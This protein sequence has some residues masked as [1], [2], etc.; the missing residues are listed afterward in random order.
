MV[1]GG[2]QVRVSFWVR[3]R[4]IS[5]QNYPSDDL[6]VSGEPKAIL[7][8]AHVTRSSS[9]LTRSSSLVYALRTVWVSVFTCLM[10]FTSAVQRRRHPLWQLAGGAEGSKSALNHPA[11]ACFP[12][13]PEAALE[14]WSITL[15][16]RWT[17]L[18]LLIWTT[19]APTS[20]EY[21]WLWRAGGD[22][23]EPAL[24]IW[25]KKECICSLT[26]TRWF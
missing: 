2:S 7:C 14:S 19:A 25:I 16:K 18:Q 15:R 21:V 20:A 9:V 1:Q 17:P 11:W 4:L 23:G 22:Q 12:A 26:P 13:C 10:V 5:I 24:G 6:T 8:S 3:G